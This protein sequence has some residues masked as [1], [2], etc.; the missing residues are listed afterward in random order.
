MKE[1]RLALLGQL[2]FELRSYRLK[3]FQTFIFAFPIIGSGFLKIA[4]DISS[5]KY[6]LTAF[7]I[8]SIFYIYKNHNRMMAIKAEIVNFQELLNLNDDFKHLSPQN[9][10]TKNFERHLG[11]FL[12]SLMLA[13][14]TVF[15]WV[16]MSVN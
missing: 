3:E 13:V 2:Y 15:L 8:F 11:T 10:L 16:K 7:A 14:E 12:Y 4:T 9:W 1:E 6:L 5:Y